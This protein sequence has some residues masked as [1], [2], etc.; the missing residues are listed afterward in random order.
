MLYNEIAEL[1]DKKRREQWRD[2]YEENVKKLEEHKDPYL[3]LDPELKKLVNEDNY[4]HYQAQIEY[5]ENYIKNNPDDAYNYKYKRM[6]E[7]L[8]IF[9]QYFEN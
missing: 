5:L 6:L 1:Y 3:D 4:L 8:K 7:E 9:V 2:K